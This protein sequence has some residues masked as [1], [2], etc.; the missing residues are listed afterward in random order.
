[1][2]KKISIIVIICIV[3][4]AVLVGVLKEYG[5]KKNNTQ[6]ASASSTTTETSTQKT[7]QSTTEESTDEIPA[8]E[9]GTEESEATTAVE[10]E[11]KETKELFRLA[12]AYIEENN[13]DSDY[14]EIKK[15]LIVQDLEHDYMYFQCKY[16]D[17]TEYA[18]YTYTGDYFRDES[19]S[20]L[21]KEYKNMLLNIDYDEDEYNIYYSFSKTEIK[22]VNEMF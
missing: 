19:Q 15:A 14:F 18:C 3:I 17:T 22:T 13:L 12:L 1:M 21:K 10:R 2:K 16:N 9:E 6:S 7:T 4:L 20:V 11:T 5:T 8:T